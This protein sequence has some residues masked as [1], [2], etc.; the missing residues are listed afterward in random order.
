MKITTLSLLLCLFVPLPAS[1]TQ[2]LQFGGDI[3]LGVSFAGEYRLQG[4]LLSDFPIDA[5][6]HT[7]GQPGV[8]DQRLRA[9][10]GLTF[11][12][13][14]VG[15]EWDLF[16]GQLFGAMWQVP[17]TLDE[18]NRHTHTV[19]TPRGFVPRKASFGFD[20][21]ALSIEAG[22]VTSHWGLG[23]MAND[24]DHDP[25]FGR[26]DFGDR[27][28]RLRVT[29]KPLY[30]ASGHAQRDFLFLT[31]AFDWVI[32]DD[33]ARIDR[34]QLALQGI[35]SLLYADPGDRRLGIYAVYRGQRE[36]TEDRFTRAI[37][38]DL[39]GQMPLALSPSGWGLM[40]AGEGAMI[41][42]TT[43]RSTSYESPDQLAVVSGGAAA[44]FTVHAPDKRLQVHLRS[45]VASGDPEPDDGVT[46]DFTFDRDFDA[47]MV[48]FDQV[49]GGIDGA[50]WALLDDPTAS[51]PPDGVDAMINE[52]AVRR[53][54]FVQPVVQGAPL[55]WLDLKL[56][57]MFASGT[58]DFAQPY[59]SFRA[60]GIPT[61]HHD[62][63]TDGRY[64][65]TEID[66]AVTVHTSIKPAVDGAPEASFLLQGG[67]LAL[68]PALQGAGPGAI[69][70]LMMTGRFRW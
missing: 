10:F 25:M 37:A 57:V 67:H 46:R 50:T 1:A 62:V 3:P 4:T 44:V 31:A 7:L 33:I 45:G 18:R 38:L 40:M 27:V 9:G 16:T 29:G 11:G 69:H 20:W 30:A 52:G 14:R 66:W 41:A 23:L 19:L 22:L 58:V 42:G 34:Q 26:N 32:A 68:G 8:A 47:G 24:G 55:G 35:L 49:M 13:F 65:G 12:R 64:L 54:A 6:G 17:C 59:Y 2:R 48:L 28:V 39:F 63:P 36:T 15:T 51:P 53:A 61:N 5:E 70:Q 21:P 60:G 56:G 43:D